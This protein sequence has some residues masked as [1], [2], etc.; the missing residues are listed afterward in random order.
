MEVLG[1]GPGPQI[2]RALSALADWVGNDDGRNDP[3][4]LRETLRSWQDENEA[5]G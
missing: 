3:I 1:T 4:R 5:D 2:G